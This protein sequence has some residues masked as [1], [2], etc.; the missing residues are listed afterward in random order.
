MLLADGHPITWSAEHDAHC[1]DSLRQDAMC[2]ADDTLLYTSG[3]ND[4]GV[5]QTR[6]CKDWDALRDWATERTACYHDI[7]LSPETQGWGDRLGHCDGGDDGL[8]RGSLLD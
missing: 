3:H 4:A 5:N 2:H 8:P 1:F 7:E 6:L